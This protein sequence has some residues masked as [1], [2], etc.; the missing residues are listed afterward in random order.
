LTPLFGDTYNRIW[1][2]VACAT[3][4]SYGYE[5]ETGNPHLLARAKKSIDYRD[6]L[7]NLVV[8]DLKV[9]YKHSFLGFF[10]SLLNPL[11]LMLVFT[12]VFQQLLHTDANS[13]QP[14]MYHVFFLSALLP[15]NWNSAAVT[16]TLGS[17]VGNGHLIKKIYFP[18]EM[19]PVSSVLSNMINYLLS[20]P[21]LLLFMVIFRPDS[22]GSPFA[23][24]C[25]YVCINSHM[26]WLPMLILTQLLFLLGLGFF[27][28]AL[29]VFF[30]DTSVLVEVGLTAW[31]FLTPIIYDTK[32][33]AGDWAN[34]MYWVNPMASVV[35]NYR[36]IFYYNQFGSPDPGFMLRNL[37][38]C[39][40][41]MV[42]GYLFF[43]RFSRNFGEEV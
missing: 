13:P 37:I 20:L 22:A 30:R 31:F 18:R 10:W 38:V 19:L 25:P 27:V 5:T 8:R 23:A 15:W 24:D 26:M 2:P 21:A 35:A 9:R 33:V 39:A 11:L 16:G 40:V 6:L 34:V 28:S 41:I 12:F 43:M 29:N 32:A 7:Y 36:D 17:I 4:V 1:Q 3:V 14:P 42:L